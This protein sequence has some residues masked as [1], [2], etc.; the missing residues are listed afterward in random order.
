MNNPT[1]LR[2]IIDRL[3]GIYGAGD[4]AGYLA[5]YAP[6]ISFCFEG[7]V[8]NFDEVCNY[9]TSLF[10]DGGKSLDFQI[11]DLDHIQFNES[12]DAAVVN[13]PWR[14]RFRHADGHETDTEFH[15]TDVW[16]RQNGQWK[17][18]HVHLSTIKNH[19]IPG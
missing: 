11:G 8:M 13:Y 19:P 1:E 9:I 16:F 3:P 17:I 10:E 4:I 6:D 12:G 2:Q 14:E 15:E 5:H 7:S 18:T